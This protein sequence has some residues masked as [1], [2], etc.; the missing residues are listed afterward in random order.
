MN[1][2]IVGVALGAL[3]LSACNKSKNSDT[4][5]VERNVLIDN[6]AAA[7]TTAS[8]ADQAFVEAAAASNMVEIES[9]K[10]ALTKATLPSIRTYAQMMI[11]DHGKASTDLAAAAAGAG[12]TVPT[13]L[14]ADQQ[15]KLDALGKLSGAAFDKQYLADQK[16]GH[17]ATLAKL[18]DYGASAPAGGLKDFANATAPVVQKHLDTLEKIK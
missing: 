9:S 6:G 8:A 10:L 18:K 1:R 2:L 12:A 14:P 16:A 11:D 7:A 3:A 15:T 4:T 17:V 5:T 13:A